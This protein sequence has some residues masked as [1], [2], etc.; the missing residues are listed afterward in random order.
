M[1]K[2]PSQANANKKKVIVTKKKA[3]VVKKV[4][5]TSIKRKSSGLPTFPYRLGTSGLSSASTDHHHDTCNPSDE[6]SQLLDS[7][8][9]DN[10]EDDVPS[11]TMMAIHS[12]QQQAQGLHI[13]LCQN[14]HS[15]VQVV[16]ENQIFARFQEDHA[17]AIW[18]ELRELT[19][20][21][22]LHKLP[23]RGI[24]HI[25]ETSTST[26]YI[27]TND[28]VT[29]VWD[30]QHHHIQAQSHYEPV[31]AWFLSSIKYW[32]GSILSKTDMELQWEQDMIIGMGQTITLEKAI[33]Y[34]F[35][36]QVLL[37]DTSTTTTASSSGDEFFVLWLPHLGTVL[38]MWNDAKRQLLSLLARS[39][40]L[41]ERNILNKN[42]SSNISTKFLLDQLSQ[43]GLV[44]FVERPFGR[45]VQRVPRKKSG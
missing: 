3:P 9:Q 17:S 32:T 41:S 34:L 20:T 30:A 36:I 37:R 16:V 24:H 5:G 39:G 21:N 45:F 15:F 25:Q 35:K 18:S 10:H 43:E 14:N 28:Y 27:V 13:P 6:L 4:V 12:L 29:A 26:V 7:P 23:C 11:D 42:R 8:N 33:H 40:E 19:R 2:C 22:Q 38:K 1:E 31:V 44:R